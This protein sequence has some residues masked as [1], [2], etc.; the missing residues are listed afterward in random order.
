MASKHRPETGKTTRS[1]WWQILL[2]VAILATT[3]SFGVMSRPSV[4]QAA[5]PN[6]PTLCKTISRDARINWPKPYLRGGT[7]SAHMRNLGFCI[8]DYKV[9][10]VKKPSCSANV[11][12]VVAKITYFKC[13]SSGSGS[14][15]L[16]QNMKFFVNVSGF[17]VAYYDWWFSV[18][19]DGWYI[20]TI[21]C[22]SPYVSPFVCARGGGRAT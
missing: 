5:T 14:S 12:L 16:T 22:S 9:S 4:A 6:Y 20:G 11:P 8:A 13:T 21:Y 10:L 2:V 18:H 19:S 3:F 17:G 1:K 7:V 15:Q